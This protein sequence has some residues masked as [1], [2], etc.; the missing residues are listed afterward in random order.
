MESR[1]FRLVA[2]LLLS[3]APC[4]ANV[5]PVSLPV[6]EFKHELD[7][8]TGDLVL[9]GIKGVVDSGAPEFELDI[10]SPGGRT[11]YMLMIYFAL[12]DAEHRGTKSRC[13]VAK[14]GFAASAAAVILQG[15]TTRIAHKSSVILFHEPA[16]PGEGKAG[17]HRRIADDLD[18]LNMLEG[19]LFGWRLHMSAEQYANWTRDRDRWLGAKDALKLGA[20]DAIE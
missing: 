1:I 7:T 4:N 10:D 12:R 14:D 3:L 15:C 13:V 18:D 2:A 5:C 17:Y 9:A 20:I 8:E 16:Q 11:D 19:A 6:V